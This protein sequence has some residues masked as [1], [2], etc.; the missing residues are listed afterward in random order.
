LWD[1]E[2]LGIK[3]SRTWNEAV[4]RYLAETSH[5]ASQVA[6][7]AHLRWVDRFLG[8]MTLGAI[9]RELLDRIHSARAAEGAANSTV[10]RTMEVIRAVLRRAANE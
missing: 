2:R 5:K 10:N 6:D 7:K 3:P 1:Q 9:D 8:G 4:V